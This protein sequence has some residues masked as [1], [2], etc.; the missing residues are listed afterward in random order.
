MTSDVT[1]A[2]GDLASSLNVMNVRVFI[3]GKTC[4][5]FVIAIGYIDNI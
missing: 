5:E 1:P 4:V 3:Y 2:G